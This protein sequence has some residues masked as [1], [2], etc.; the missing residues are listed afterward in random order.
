[1][2]NVT[3]VQSNVEYKIGV[4]VFDDDTGEIF[5]VVKCDRISIF[6]PIL[7]GVTLKEVKGLQ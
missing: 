5:E 7:Y 2:E 6:T 4:I 3:K 1:M